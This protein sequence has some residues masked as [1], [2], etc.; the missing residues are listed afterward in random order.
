[1]FSKLGILQVVSGNNLLKI[2]GHNTSSNS[3][4]TVIY[5][6]L[7]N[8]NENEIFPLYKFKNLYSLEKSYLYGN[9]WYD[10]F[11]IEIS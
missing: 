7:R 3:S 5:L 9:A 11:L 4:S 10:C 6:H 1:M 8:Q 2:A